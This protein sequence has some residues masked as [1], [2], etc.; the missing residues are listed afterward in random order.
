MFPRLIASPIRSSIAEIVQLDFIASKNKA[1]NNASPLYS[2]VAA[3][4]WMTE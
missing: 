1:K 2:G 4:P 3:L